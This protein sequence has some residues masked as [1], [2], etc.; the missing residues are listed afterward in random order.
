[1]SGLVDRHRQER[2]ETKFER[3]HRVLSSWSWVVSDLAAW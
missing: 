1:V 3:R 2:V